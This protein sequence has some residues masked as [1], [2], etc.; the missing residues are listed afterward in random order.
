M[1]RL[2]RLPVLGLIAVLAFACG[3][4][5]DVQPQ[6]VATGTPAASAT[7]TAIATAPLVI[8]PTV[9]ITP[10]SIALPAD[11]EIYLDPQLAF[12]LPH[13]SGLMMREHFFD[14]QEQKSS[15]AIQGRVISFDRPDGVF[16]LY[17]AIAPNSAG[18]SLEEW[19]KT[20]P[21]WPAEPQPFVV[22]GER[23]LWF[24]RNALD[25]PDAKVYFAHAEMVYML[26]GN[27]F[28]SGEN[29][30]GPAIGEAD[31]QIVLQLFRFGQQ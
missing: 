16:A 1:S 19:I 13:P 3:D 22:A 17:V 26:S 20:Y 18:L 8:V 11:W 24:A 28:G 31:F 25:E 2:W 6:S 29:G 23:A 12:S 30:Y 9:A 15:S 14:L 27:V 5:G 7:P 21:G 4:S 10:A